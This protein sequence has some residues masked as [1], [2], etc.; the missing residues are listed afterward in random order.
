MIS[1]GSALVVLAATGLFG[2]LAPD[3]YRYWK[4]ILEELSFLIVLVGVPIGLIQYFRAVKKEQIDREYGTYNA[5]DEKFL[6]FQN[7]CLA[8][9]DLDIFDV[10]DKTPGTLTAEQQKKEL[11]AFT[12]LFSIFERAYLMYHDQS[13]AIQQRPSRPVAVGKRNGSPALAEARPSRAQ[14]TL[15]IQ[16]PFCAV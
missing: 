1:V 3:S 11:I 8:H 9:P 16:P 6:E 14:R 13:T 7:M 12:I 5:L 2:K 4:D 15:P 10:P